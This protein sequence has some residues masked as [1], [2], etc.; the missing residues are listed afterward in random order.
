MF[1]WDGERCR[2]GHYQHQHPCPITPGCSPCCT[3][4]GTCWPLCLDAPLPSCSPSGLTT[5]HRCS[6]CSSHAHPPNH[7]PHSVCSLSPPLLKFCMC[8]CCD[9]FTFVYVS[10]L[11]KKPS[12]SCLPP[13]STM[14]GIE[15]L[16]ELFKGKSSQLAHLPVKQICQLLMTPFEP[17]YSQA[18][19][20]HH[21]PPQTCKLTDECGMQVPMM[22]RALSCLFTGALA[23]DLE[24]SEEAG[25]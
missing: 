16:S 5:P 13:V 10:L 9:S 24:P 25:I 4:L 15:L 11:Q 17:E 3:S 19:L 22:R 2:T 12:N 1:L 14:P 20:G 23:F 18:F 21:C 6:C 7:S 8:F